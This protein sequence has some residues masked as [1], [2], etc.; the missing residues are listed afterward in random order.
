M[1]KGKFEEFYFEGYYS[2]IGDFSPKRDR[3]LSNWFR[4]MFEYINRYYPIKNGRGKK[5]IEFGCATGAAANLLAD[6]GFNVFSTDVSKYAVNLAAKNYPDVRFS[7]QDMQKQFTKD[8][9]FDVACAFDVIEHLKDPEKALRNTYKVLKPRGI[10]ILTT[11]NDYKHM[12][13]DP[14]H[15]NVKKPSEWKK[16]LKRVG[17]KNIIINQIAFIPYLYRFHWRLNYALPLAISSPY[18]IS[19]VVIVAN[20]PRTQGVRGKL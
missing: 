8:K 13:N 7:V 1:K 12:P 9:N 11:P 19:P 17:F 18:I 2:G 15:I 6:Y 16:I 20:K 3:E 4:A 10:I 14:T 5:L